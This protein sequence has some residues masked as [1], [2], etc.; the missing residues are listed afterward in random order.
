MDFV[1]FKA[2]GELRVGDF[3]IF[4]DVVVESD[5]RVVKVKAVGQKELSF[6]RQV[7]RKDATISLEDLRKELAV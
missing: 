3:R 6:L 7:S 2:G 5:P 1:G 4:Y